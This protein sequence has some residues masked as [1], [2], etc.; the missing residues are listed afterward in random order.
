[1]H[2]V[3]HRLRMLGS[4]RQLAQGCQRPSARP[5]WPVTESSAGTAECDRCSAPMHQL[6]VLGQDHLRDSVAEVRIDGPRAGKLLD[7]GPARALAQHHQQPWRAGGRRAGRACARPSRR[8]SLWACA[9][10]R[11][12]IGAPR[13]AHLQHSARPL[14]AAQQRQTVALQHHSGSCGRG[15]ADAGTGTLGGQGPCR[16]SL[17]QLASSG[18]PGPRGRAC[19]QV[20][21]MHGRGELRVVRQQQARHVARGRAVQDGE[22]A[23]ALTRLLPLSQARAPYQALSAAPVCG[24]GAARAAAA[25]LAS[26]WTRRQ[27]LPGAGPIRRP[28]KR[29]HIP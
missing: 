23:A 16:P 28:V 24:G 26:H 3:R 17:R 19:G 6:R 11:A 13:A 20:Q 21:H 25:C 4:D 12:N 1:M 8:G 22:R 18:T 29:R 15:G 2:A 5:D 9:T 10:Q 14:A 27:L 7:Q